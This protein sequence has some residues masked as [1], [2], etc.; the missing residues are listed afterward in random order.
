M[1][2]MVLGKQQFLRLRQVRI[3]LGVIIAFNESSGDF[4]TGDKQKK[5]SI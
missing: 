1:T 3:L 2:A 4:I 5:T